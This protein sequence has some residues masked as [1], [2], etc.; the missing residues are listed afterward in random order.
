[1]QSKHK[2][3]RLFSL[4]L[5]QKDRM[6]ILQDCRKEELSIDFR[7]FLEILVENK[8]FL[9]IFWA[10]L[11]KLNR[12][13]KFWVNHQIFHYRI[14]YGTS[15]LQIHYPNRLENPDPVVFT[16]LI[17]A[18]LECRSREIY[19]YLFHLTKKAS[20]SQLN[21]D[22]QNHSF[23]EKENLR[24]QVADFWEVMESF[25]GVHVQKC[26]ILH[27]E[28][29]MEKA[30]LS[31]FET[32]SFWKRNFFTKLLENLRRK[33]CP[34]IIRVKGRAQESYLCGTFLH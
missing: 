12:K 32:K 13:L 9:A 27:R 17:L 25:T 15:S 24:I 1:M 3:L 19:H 8:N 26:S 31:A 10:I 11:S 28:F 5:D 23:L 29:W 7:E 22:L 6:S 16:F 14:K 34:L 30:L 20:E 4:Y 33:D 18:V 2:L 21:L